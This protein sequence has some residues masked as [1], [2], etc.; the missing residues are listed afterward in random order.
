MTKLLV[1]NTSVIC[2]LLSL[3]LHGIFSEAAKKGK[4]TVILISM[5]GMGWQYISGQFADTPNLDAV[6]RNGVRAKYT[7]NVVPTITWPTHHSYVTGLYPESHGIV[8]NSFWDPVYKENFIY[9]YDCSN[10]DPKFYNA[11]E[12]IWLTLQKQG[13]RS[14][15]YF[16]PGS[17][18]YREKPTYYEKPICLVNCSAINPKDLPKYRKKARKTWPSYIHCLPN[19]TEPFTSRLDK[20]I[21]WLKSDKPP[22]FVAVYIDHPDWEGHEYGPQSKEYK[23]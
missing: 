13:G 21:K 6:G 12:P 11:S 7:I 4:E 19:Y 15:V 1:R 2:L 22:Q 3:S 9:D 10:Y 17:S 14:G 23:A 8:S 20:V 16:W 5:D 18:G